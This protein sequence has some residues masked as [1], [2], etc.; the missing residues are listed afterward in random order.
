M[1]AIG[2]EDA[3]ASADTTRNPSTIDAGDQFRNERQSLHKIPNPEDSLAQHEDERQAASNSSE[4]LPFRPPSET[5]TIEY[6][7]TPFVEFSE[8]VK[9]LCHI[10]WP[11]SPSTTEHR[12]ERLLGS[13]NSK[14]LGALRANKI[15]RF[16]R[17]A[18]S[19]KEFLIERLKGGSFNRIIGITILDSTGE[20]PIQLI[21]RVP[22]IEW[23]VRLDRD[24]AILQYVKQHTSIPLADIKAFDFT[25]NNPLKSPYIIQNRLPG[26]SLR[27]AHLE[28]LSTEEWCSVARE[29][30]HIMLALQKTTRPFPGLVEAGTSESG[31]QV[32]TVCPFDIKSPFDMNWKAN[33]ATYAMTYPV[34]PGDRDEFERSTFYLLVELLGRWRAR[35]LRNKPAGILYWHHMHRLV[36]VASQ[37][38]E[39]GFLGDNSNN[40]CHLDL[41]DRNIMV[42]RQSNNTLT[43]TGILDWDSAVFA[44]KFVSCAPPWWMW[45]DE[46]STVDSEQDEDGASDVPEKHHNRLIKA[47]FDETVGEDFLHYCYQ[48]QYKYARRLFHIAMTGNHGSYETDIIDVFLR[49]WA[50]FYRT[51]TAKDCGNVKEKDM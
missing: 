34:N 4:S 38:N 5:S 49:D 31:E 43:V 48:P 18:V 42:Q 41:A 27:A 44:P 10:L 22:R 16:L 24:V 20:D 46:D 2:A 3:A 13:S 15:G 39:M 12:V 37:M 21:L 26:A 28:G 50:V 30:G 29:V 40:L 51:M 25:N 33:A 17:P 23:M 47:A 6:E 35:E 14:I 11:P 1:S 7:Q 19:S 9:A 36:D 32:F 45:Q 8:Q